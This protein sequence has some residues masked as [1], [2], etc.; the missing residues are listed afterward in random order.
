MR[1]RWHLAQI[2]IARLIAPADAPEVAGFFAQLDRVNALADDASGFVWRL[3][4]E[5]GNAT[6]LQ[7][8][9]DPR[10]IVNMS[11][12]S[13]AESLF[14]FVYRSAHTPVMA[15]RRDWFERF[16]SAYQA[17]WWVPAGHIPDVDEG[18]ARLWMLDRFGPSPNAF[19]FKARFPAPGSGAPPI[20]MKPDPWCVGTA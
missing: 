12:W 2:N 9:P 8:T 15:R 14:E 3:Q 20:D 17:L 18:L 10:L 1:E 11:V 6:G 4:E 13:D 7:P 5:G 19:T 16:E